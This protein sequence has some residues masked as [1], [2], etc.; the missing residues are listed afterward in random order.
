MH[1]PFFFS[2]LYWMRAPISCT[3]SCAHFSTP[4]L[5][6]TGECVGGREGGGGGGAPGAGMEGGCR[7]G[8]CLGQAGTGKETK[9]AEAVK[10]QAETYRD[11]DRQSQR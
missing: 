8:S 5:L 2:R 4:F 3:S 7:R 6:A 11:R 10:K 1:S 9:N